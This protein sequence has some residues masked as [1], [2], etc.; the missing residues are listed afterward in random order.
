MTDLGNRAH[1]V[2]VRLGRRGPRD[3]LLEQQHQQQPEEA[4]GAQRGHQLC[5]YRLPAVLGHVGQGVH[6]DVHHAYHHQ[7]HLS[8]RCR[9]PALLS[10][11]WG[12][13]KV[14]V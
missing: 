11:R 6:E 8:C 13:G 2:A 3:V 1:L 4:A 12:G 5:Q 10:L 14:T 7:L 9:S